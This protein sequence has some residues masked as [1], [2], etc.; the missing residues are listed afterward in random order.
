VSVADAYDTM[1]A[2]RSY[3]R[4][5][6]TRAAREELA[7]CAGTQFDPVMVRSFLG[8]SVPRLV[9]VSGP[10]SFVLHLPYLWRLQ[11]AGE[12]AVGAAAQAA[13]AGAV[14]TAAAVV[15]GGSMPGTVGGHQAAG[16][17]SNASRVSGLSASV[18]TVG[19]GRGPAAE[20]NRHGAHGK[21]PSPEP[22]PVPEPSPTP[23]GD[24]G[25][26]LG[27]QLPLPLPSLPTKLPVKPP[28]DLPDPPKLPTPLPTKLPLGLSQD[29]Q[30]A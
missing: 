22:T 18:T 8:I 29:D 28:V 20:R 7:R 24:D 1:T 16:G 14:V 4:P 19:H 11:R 2:A 23:T 3:K 26:L 17:P 6:A 21:D 25:S 10:A 27:V 12:V 5:M 9:W 13:A 30:D 15:I